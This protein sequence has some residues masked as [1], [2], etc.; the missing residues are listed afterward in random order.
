MKP[1][2]TSISVLAFALALT[3]CASSGDTPQEK[4]SASGV[5]TVEKAAV[6]PQHTAAAR[7]SVS[8]IT[9]TVKTLDIENRMVTLLGPDGDEVAFSVGEQVRNLDQV[10]VGDKVTVEYY[11]GLVA[12]LRT[13]ADAQQGAPVETATVMG[14]AALGERPAG[15]VG[16]AV[17][18]RVVI[19]FVDPVRNVVHFKGPLGK[20]HIVE[21]VK[22]EFRAM[23]KNLKAGDQVDLT[24]FEALAVS[25]TPAG[26]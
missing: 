26:D 17:R 5:L 13:D 23:L 6:N 12:D 21:V 19:E 4:T 7:V 16:R 10:K 11:D 18:A 3:G 25:V 15:A 14:R 8:K 22:P 2:S 1:H 20:T 24:F 9:A